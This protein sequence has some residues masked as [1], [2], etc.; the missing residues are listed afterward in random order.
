MT[1]HTRH[2]AAMIGRCLTV[3]AVMIASSC[4]RIDIY[5]PGSEASLADINLIYDWGK[6]AG[7]KSDEMYVITARLNE[8]SHTYFVTDSNSLFLYES[9]Y[10]PFIEDNVVDKQPADTLVADTTVTD[11]VTV[12]NDTIPTANGKESFKILNGDYSILVVSKD[13]YTEIVPLVDFVTRPEAIGMKDLSM[14]Y[15]EITDDSMMPTIDGHPWIDRNPGY[16]FISNS[17]P[18]FMAKNIKMTFTNGNASG[19]RLLGFERLT[20]NIRFN[21]TIRVTAE[22]GDS[23]SIGEDGVVAEISGVVPSIKLVDE[24][25]QAVSL[26]R[27]FLD[28]KATQ[29][30]HAAGWAEYSYE[31][32]IDAFTIIAGAD[33]DVVSGPGILRIGI[34]LTVIDSDGNK[35]SHVISATQN[36]CP[37]ITSARLTTIGTDGRTLT[38]ATKDASIRVGERLDID[39]TEIAQGNSNGISG[40]DEMEIEE[41]I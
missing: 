41:E 11:S 14:T 38:Q 24:T 33:N 1:K 10:S 36:I 12:P 6:Y 31:G 30:S 26:K 39:A 2:K 34:G 5:E 7:Q 19:E 16:K 9:P 29:T 37:E 27:M 4:E 15:N 40:W 35:T 3:M 32:H 25:M 23:I 22:D 18:K 20:Q 13:D 28:G 17:G 8:T 21:F